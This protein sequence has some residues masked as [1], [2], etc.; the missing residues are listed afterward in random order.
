MNIIEQIQRLS[1]AQLKLMRERLSEGAKA[2]REPLVRQSRGNTAPLSF[3]QERLWFME[4]MGS[5]G[6]EYILPLDLR[7]GGLLDVNGLEEA[8]RLLLE[9]HEILRTRIEERDGKPMQII[10]PSRRFNLLVS[11]LSDLPESERRQRLRAVRR[12]QV[13]TP[14]DLA[15]G[16]LWRVSLVRLS[17]REHLLLLT[18]HHLIA[19][20]G[21]WQ[22]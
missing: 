13:D 12:E 6:A 18:M 14:F 15:R 10:E 20:G 17:D 9:R 16:P 11:D 5:L 8:F 21:R 19:D 1:P 2:V 4:Q 22:C 3:G 7:V